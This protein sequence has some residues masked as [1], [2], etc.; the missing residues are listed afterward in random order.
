MVTARERE[1]WSF[2]GIYY[3]FNE[4]WLYIEAFA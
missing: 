2:M 1:K 3:K 4:V